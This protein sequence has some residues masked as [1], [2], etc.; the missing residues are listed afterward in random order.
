[1]DAGNNELYAVTM[2]NEVY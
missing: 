2:W 1:M